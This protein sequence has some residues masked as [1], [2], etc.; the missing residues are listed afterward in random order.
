MVRS[1][2]LISG[3]SRSRPRQFDVLC[4]GPPPGLAPLPVPP[5]GQPPLS[6][7]GRVG[8]AGRLRHGRLCEYR[9]AKRHKCHGLFGR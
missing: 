8:A 2:L 6:G 5:A 3:S 4:S 1:D 7:L 9:G